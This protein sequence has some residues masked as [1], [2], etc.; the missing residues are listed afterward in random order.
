[1][2]RNNKVKIKYERIALKYDSSRFKHE[3]GKIID[4]KQKNVLNNVIKYL[5]LDSKIS[6]ILEVGSGSGR[7]LNFL[8]NLGFCNC[9]GLDQSINMIKITLDKKGN[10]DLV[11]AD[12]YF[13]PFK[14]ASFEF[15]F[16]I[17]VLMHVRNPQKFLN[18]MM[19]VSS[20]Y[21]LIDFNNLWSIRFLGAVIEKIFSKKKSPKRYTYREISQMIYNVEGLWK[22]DKI[23]P[24][25]YLPLR[26]KAPKIYFQKYEIL[27]YLFGKLFNKMASQYFVLIR[28]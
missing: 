28:K 6:T 7:F 5:E 13:L 10:N 24:I 25:F 23:Y 26:I 4:R 1:M 27:Q 18:E 3:G 20:K 2:I 17:H 11:Y 21:L 9:Y 22:I 16:S 15:I 14:D 8:K 12:G 19:R